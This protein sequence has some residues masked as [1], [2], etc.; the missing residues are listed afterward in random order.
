MGDFK[1]V[2]AAMLTPLGEGGAAPSARTVESYC[3]FLLERGVSGLFPLGTTGEWPLLREEERMRIAELVVGSAKAWRDDPARGARPGADSGPAK[4]IVHAGADSTDETV[5]LCRHA[6]GIGADAVGVICPPYY[7]L[8]EEAL[9]FHF[10]TAARSVPDLPFFVYFIPSLVRCDMTP[11]LLLNL[12]READNIVGLK[13]S[14]ESIPRFREYR[15][16]LGP[17]FSLFIGDDNHALPGLR[18]GADGIVSGNA[19]AMPEL[20]VDLYRSFRAGEDEAATEAQREL[21]DFIAGIDGRAELSSF[22]RILGIRGVPA[23]E[24][25]RPLNPLSPDG[26]EALAARIRRL[27]ERNKARKPL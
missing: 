3:R 12:T 1:G 4:V 13:Y 15:R 9:H 25:R 8:D 24:V 21:D 17:S 23:G 14:G 10:I 16:V 27:E 5:R 20:L 19:S 18:E 22:K 2:Y 7:P 11:A 6:R 26:S